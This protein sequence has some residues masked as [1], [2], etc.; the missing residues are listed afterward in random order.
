MN[1]KDCEGCYSKAF[2]R[3][4]EKKHFPCGI[5][6]HNRPHPANIPICPCV[7][8]VVKVMCNKACEEY[9]AYKKKGS[10]K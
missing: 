8:C 4:K 3:G 10:Y 9:K 2:M 7:D 5:V 6:Y 1:I